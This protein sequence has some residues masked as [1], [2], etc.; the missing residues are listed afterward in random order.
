MIVNI[1]KCISLF[2]FF[3][4]VASSVG[5][6]KLPQIIRD[7]MILQ[8]DAKIKI[9]GWA[10]KDEK[11]SISFNGKKYNTKTGA[12][13]KWMTTL[14]A[15][16]AGGP[17]TM[18]ISAS[19]KITLNDIL[20][21]DV[22][23]C[24]G[25]SNMEYQ[26]GYDD[27]TYGK[28]MAEVNNPQIRQFKVPNR[29]L[30][31]GPKEEMTGGSWKTA[32]PKDIGPFTAIGY[33]FAKNLY[34]KYHVPI[35]IINSS[36]GGTPIEAWISS[37]GLKNIKTYHNRIAQFGNAAFMDSVMKT[38][39]SPKDI[40]NT[41]ANGPDKGLTESKPWYDT[42]YVPHNWHRFWLPGY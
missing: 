2:L 20:I 11:V 42:T 1:K 27:A 5:Q 35:G 7:S 31:D 25:Q 28:E 17:Y 22:W 26:L 29:P 39:S 4:I 36:V 8:R 21:G 13:G 38:R 19:N 10:A 6:V 40:F 15:M 24:S 18:D 23:L 34:E 3:F 16:K 30:L 41:S 37:D 14:P 9:W 12:D 33:F 32:N